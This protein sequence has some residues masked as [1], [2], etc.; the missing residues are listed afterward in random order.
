LAY[1][2]GVV[3]SSEP[4]GYAPPPANALAGFTQSYVT[5][6]PG[7]ALPSA[8]GSY[9]GSIGGDPGAQY[10]QKHV[11]VGGGLLQFNTYQDPAFNNAWITGGAC[12][13]NLAAQTY[14]AWFVR[15]RLTGPGATEVELLVPDANVWPPELDFNESYADTTGTSATTHYGAGDATIER[16]V[17][18]DLTQWHTWG[19]IWTPTSLTYTVD[20]N[21]WG[22]VDTAAAIPT[23]PM[24]LSLQQQTWCASNWACPTAN[25]SLDVDWVAQYTYNN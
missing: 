14:G 24:H 22:T 23:I 6:F 17:N 16:T 12:D 9:E 21:V 13:C 25:S 2:I 5:D 10:D 4:S 8:W 1:P 20:G 7:T 11:T 3:E 15:S 18:I 19:L